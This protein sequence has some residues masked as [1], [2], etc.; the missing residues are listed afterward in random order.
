MVIT[1]LDYKLRRTIGAGPSAYDGLSTIQ[2]AVFGGNLVVLNR[3]LRA[4]ADVNSPPVAP[5]GM[6]ALQTAAVSGNLDVV[7]S[8]LRAGAD[9][10]RPEHRE[11]RDELPSKPPPRQGIGTLCSGF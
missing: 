9:I 3:L 2:A 5:H 10:N 8:L 11:T 7:N 1:S 6:T 4:G